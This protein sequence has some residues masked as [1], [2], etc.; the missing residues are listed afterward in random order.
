MRNLL[1]TLL[2]LVSLSLISLQVLAGPKALLTWT[3]PATRVDQTPIDCATEIDHYE[4]WRSGKLHRSPVKPKATVRI[5]YGRVETFKI[6]SVDT[7]GQKSETAATKTAE[8]MCV[9]KP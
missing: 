7:L 1:I 3:C 8:L 4:V 9:L 5:R 2:M 6:Y